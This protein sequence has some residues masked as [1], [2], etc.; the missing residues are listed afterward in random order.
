[1][2]FYA[3]LDATWGKLLTYDVLCNPKATGMHAF[4]NIIFSQ[5]GVKSHRPIGIKT[6]DEGY[7]FLGWVTWKVKTVPKHLLG[8]LSNESGKCEEMFFQVYIF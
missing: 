2:V 5:T 4:I 1:M 7:F 6:S 8:V 3:Q